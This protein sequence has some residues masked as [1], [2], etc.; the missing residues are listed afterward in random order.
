M[1]VVMTHT[2]AP[3][4]D[5]LYDMLNAARQKA[6]E[7]SPAL[8]PAAEHLTAFAA[9]QTLIELTQQVHHLTLATREHNAEL[10]RARWRTE[11]S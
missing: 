6:H 7:E 5:N 2:P 1:I 9:I 4:I 3:G 8:L 11:G 10:E